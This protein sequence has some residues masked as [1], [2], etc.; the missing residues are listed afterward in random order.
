[1]LLAECWAL[2][3]YK[4]LVWE[5][6]LRKQNIH[7]NVTLLDS[8]GA[9]E[10]LWRHA[11][12]QWTGTNLALWPA[13]LPMEVPPTTNFCGISNTS[14]L[15]LSKFAHKKWRRTTPNCFCKAPLR[16]MLERTVA[17]WRQLATKI[18]MKINSQGPMLQC[19]W[20]V[21][22]VLRIFIWQQEKTKQFMGYPNYEFLL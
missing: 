13:Q 7:S 9:Q 3:L 6:I 8:Q 15:T 11:Q 10:C 14:F 1:M 12:T 18:L 4:W 5:I 16:Q 2:T 21:S 22:R 17:S 20:I 19:K